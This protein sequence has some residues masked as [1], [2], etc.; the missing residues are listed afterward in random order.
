[1][2]SMRGVLS[3]GR[4]YWGT[5]TGFVRV[6]LG[7]TRILRWYQSLSKICWPPTIGSL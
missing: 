3:I 7:S 6:E 2:Q 5:Q 4:S 1:M